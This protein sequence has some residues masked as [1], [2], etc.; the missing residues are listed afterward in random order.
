MH[1]DRGEGD[2]VAAHQ[3][4][5][6]PHTNNV[7]PGL[8]PGPLTRDLP[9]RHHQQYGDGGRWA[10][11]E[12]GRARRDGLRQPPTL[13][14]TVWGGEWVTAVDCRRL[15]IV[16]EDWASP[17]CRLSRHDEQPSGRTGKLARDQTGWHWRN[18]ETAEGK[19]PALGDG[20]RGEGRLLGGPTGRGSGGGGKGQHTCNARPLAGTLAEIRLGVSPH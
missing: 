9:V 18:L 2:G 7:Q 5:V 4:P 6:G 14:A 16:A 1:K 20:A 13:A 17:M 19:V 8:L 11:I 15:H 12:R 10:T 3:A